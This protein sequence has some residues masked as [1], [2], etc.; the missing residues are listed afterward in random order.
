PGRRSSWSGMR[1]LVLGAGV[2][3]LAAIRALTRVGAEVSVADDRV[4]VV[5][6]D[7]SGSTVREIAMPDQVPDVDLVLATPG[8][9][10]GHR[11]LIS[12]RAAG[13]EIIAEP[14]LAWRM[15]AANAAPWLVVT[16]TNGKTTTVGMLASMLTAAGMASIATG[17]IGLP[18][19]DVVTGPVQYDVLA[20]ELS[21]FQLGRSPSIRAHAATVLNL[22]PD[23]LD[24]HGSMSAYAMAKKVAFEQAGTAVVNLDDEWSSRLARDHPHRVGFTLGHPARGALGVADGVLLDR[25][26]GASVEIAGIGDIPVPGQHNVANALAAAALARSMVVPSSAVAQGLRAYRPGPHRNTLVSIV[27]GVAFVDD[28]KATNPHAAQASLSAYPDV[29]WIAGGLLKGAEVDDLVIAVQDRLRAVVLIGADR[30]VI[31]QALGRHAPEVP[32]VEVAT[33]DD[34]AMV[35]VVRAAFALARPG[36]TVLLAP[37]AAS[38]DMFVNYVARA[39]AFARAVQDLGGGTSP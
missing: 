34:G 36:S 11:L 7:L 13:V 14:E 3:G 6:D 25:A 10:P 16:G 1:V 35:E 33:N 15:R 39:D 24:W 29:V 9:A 31:G 22:A 26:Y 18:L 28:S 4:G 17:N 32:V 21:S 27:D 37:A 30:A 20:V 5:P 8:I 2:S 12:A 38:M 19:I 23:H